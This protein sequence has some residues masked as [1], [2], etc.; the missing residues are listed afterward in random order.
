VIIYKLLEN[1]CD[2]LKRMS[3]AA[4]RADRSPGEVELVAVTKTV[5]LERIQEA[6]DAGLRVFGENKVQEAAPKIEHFRSLG[7]IRW[8]FIG[9][10]QKNKAKK[11]VEL[12][13]V[14]ESVDSF[15]LAERINRHADELNKIQPVFIQVKLGEEETKHGAAP[16]DVEE[17]VSE[18]AAL[19]NIEM[20]G[21]M[22]I[23]PYCE[24]PEEARSYFSQLRKIRD[25]LREKGY[26]IQRLSM[27][28]SHDFE[29]AVQEGATEIRV[30]TDIF[31]RR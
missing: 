15:E 17:L 11:A 7:T 23:P 27:G 12:F 9:P 2:I 30:G 10:L 31:G 28:M 22:A 29:I 3:H 14:I 20:I 19:K 24:D 6:I 8:H 13:D 26:G 25:L 16:E 18:M 5:S 4:M 1:A 21:L